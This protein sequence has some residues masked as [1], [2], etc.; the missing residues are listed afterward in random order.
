MNSIPP[1]RRQGW[2]EDGLRLA[3]LEEMRFRVGEA[4]AI[5]VGGNEVSGSS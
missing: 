3:F 5:G 2:C 1:V 4:A